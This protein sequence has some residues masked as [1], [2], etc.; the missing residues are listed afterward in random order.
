M[1]RLQSLG[2]QKIRSGLLFNQLARKPIG[3]QRQ[4]QIVELNL[5]FGLNY[6][7]S[8]AARARLSSAELV[9]GTFCRAR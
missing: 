5:R 3:W 9:T 6:E 2:S 1:A 8:P 4:N 7:V